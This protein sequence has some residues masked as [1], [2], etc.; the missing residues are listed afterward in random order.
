MTTSGAG[1][2]ILIV[3]SLATALGGEVNVSSTSWCT[4]FT[5]VLPLHHDATSHPRFR[6]AVG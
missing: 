5:V 6:R 3:R 4:A 1:L 2:G